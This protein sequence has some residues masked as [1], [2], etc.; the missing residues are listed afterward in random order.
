MRF[1][2]CAAAMAISVPVM[3]EKLTIDRIYSD[4]DLNG[5]SPR[6]LRSLRSA[7]SAR[8]PIARPEVSCRAR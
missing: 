4:P 2:L 5:P 8:Y 1:L 6:A 7:S 3:A